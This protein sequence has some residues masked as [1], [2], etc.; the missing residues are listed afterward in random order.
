MHECNAYTCC[1]SVSSLKSWDGTSISSLPV[2]AFVFVDQLIP[3]RGQLL[4]LPQSSSWAPT[5]TITRMSDMSINLSGTS[6]PACIFC[7][8][9]HRTSHRTCPSVHALFPTRRTGQ[10][11]CRQNGHPHTP[12]PLPARTYETFWGSYRPT[13]PCSASWLASTALLCLLPTG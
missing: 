11:K 2:T 12:P 8:L 7:V 4:L 5:K 9:S 10:P 13:P 3:R 6:M 1:L